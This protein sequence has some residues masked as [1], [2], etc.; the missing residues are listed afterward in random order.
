MKK[1]DTK[2]YSWINSSAMIQISKISVNINREIMA[3]NCDRMNKIISQLNNTYSQIL[4]P[5][6]EAMEK[7]MANSLKMVIQ[8]S[9]LMD[10]F[11]ESIRS[12]IKTINR[13]YPSMSV[14]QEKLLFMKIADELEFPVYFY[15]DSELRKMLIESYRKNGNCC[16]KSE[17][18]KIILDYF[19]DAYVDRL[20]CG[21]RNEEIFNSRISLIEE[22]IQAYRLQLYGPSGALFVVL[23]GGMIQDIYDEKQKYARLSKKQKQQLLIE[24]NQH[25]STESEKG[26]LI[27]IIDSQQYGIY[28][29]Y[30]VVEY[31]LKVFYSCNGCHMVVSPQR[32]KICH[33]EQI[34]FNTKEMN[35]KLLLSMEILLELAAHTKRM[36][37]SENEEIID[38]PQ[39]K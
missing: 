26:M 11:G 25:C 4:S 27:Q 15:V 16:N 31:F 36:Y 20:L 32:N 5:V 7:S 34:N 8:T 29:W 9:G 17:M 18:T 22:G 19:G 28:I 13:I 39:S 1:L 6:R 35:L 10:S 12:A 37:S 30:E 3:V 24:Y 23:M 33:G 14:V 2:N 21:L 38:M